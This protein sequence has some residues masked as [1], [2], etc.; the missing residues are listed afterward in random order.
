MTGSDDGTYCIASLG[1]QDASRQA[2][3]H[4]IVRE[5]RALGSDAPVE[6]SRDADGLHL[7]T[8]LRSDMPIVFKL[9][10]D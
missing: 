8:A 1:E 2:N 6:W 5:V 4:G 7:K 10:V 3:F 9:T